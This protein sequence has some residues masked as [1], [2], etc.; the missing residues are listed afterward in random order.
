MPCLARKIIVTDLS[1]LSN[2]ASPCK[3]QRDISFNKSTSVHTTALFWNQFE[4]GYIS[5]T[6]VEKALGSRVPRGAS[7]IYPTAKITWRLATLD[8]G[9]ETSHLRV[10]SELDHDVVFGRGAGCSSW[11]HLPVNQQQLCNTSNQQLYNSS[12]QPYAFQQGSREVASVVE[13]LVK[14]EDPELDK[15]LADSSFVRSFASSCGIGLEGEL[16]VKACA[17]RIRQRIKVLKHGRPPE[18]V[19]PP[20]LARTGTLDAILRSETES[21]VSSGFDEDDL[22]YLGSETSSEMTWE[23]NFHQPPSFLCDT[24][25]SSAEDIHNTPMQVAPVIRGS[26]PEDS[27]HSWQLVENASQQ[28]LTEEDG[29]SQTYRTGTE[30]QLEIPSDQGQMSDFEMHPGHKVWEWDK[31]IQRWKRRGRSGQEETDWFPESFA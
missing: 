25:Q 22:A 13:H 12:N 3:G 1:I 21:S 29:P 19:N 24:N 30:E 8:Q 9:A 10:V 7:G 11:K 5:I 14:L 27:I 17:N 16:S 26:S 18:S 4:G 20:L 6:I 2:S 28:G 15:K 31:D 23:R